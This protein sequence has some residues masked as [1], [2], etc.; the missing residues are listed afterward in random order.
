MAL[1]TATI[2]A[3]ISAV[4]G[5]AGVAGALSQRS[6]AKKSRKAQERAAEVANKQASIQR[7]RDVRRRIAQARVQRAEIESQGFARGVAGSSMVS[8][9]LGGLSSDTASTVGFSNQ[10]AGMEQARVGFLN[11]AAAAQSRGAERAAIFGGI[12]QAAGFFG[13]MFEEQNT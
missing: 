11:E 10:M 8:G 7:Q 4:A 9:A 1:T 6:A 13:P 5:V 12:Q 2:I 3:G